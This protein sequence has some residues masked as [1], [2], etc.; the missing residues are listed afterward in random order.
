MVRDYLVWVV[1]LGFP[2]QAP[3]WEFIY[4]KFIYLWKV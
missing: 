1:L 2:A 3:V 4:G